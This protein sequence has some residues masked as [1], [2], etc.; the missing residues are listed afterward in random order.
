MKR[1]V[2]GKLFFTSII[3]IFLSS[4]I[5]AI[6]PTPGNCSIATRAE[7]IDAGINVAGMHILMGLSASTNAHGQSFPNSDYPSVLCCFFGMGNSTCLTTPSNK[8]IGLSDFTNAHAEAPDITP[9][10]QT[11]KVCYDDLSC[12][13]TTSSSCPVDHPKGILSLSS[14]TNAHL[15]NFSDFPTKICCGGTSIS[16]LSCT[17]K[18]ATWGQTSVKSGTGVYLNVV[19]S[20]TECSGLTLSFTIS[21]GSNPVTNPVSVSFNGNTARAIWYGER[22]AG[23]LG[24]GDA[25]YKFN[26]TL[27][28]S[29]PLRSMLSSNSLTVKPRTGDCAL[30]CG[31]YTD[32]QECITD[33]PCNVSTTEGISQG[34]ACDGIK[35]ICSCSWDSTASTCSFS[36]TQIKAGLTPPGYTLCKD[37]ISGANYNYPGTSCPGNSSASNFDGICDLNDGCSSTDCSDG[38]QASCAQGST[39]SGGKCSGAAPSKVNCSYGFTLC[40]SSSTPFCFPGNKCPSGNAPTGNSNGKCEVGEGCSLPLDCKDGSQDSCAD[41]TYCSGGKCGSVENPVTILTLGYCKITQTLIKDCNV[42]PV[43]YKSFTM[44]GTWIGDASTKTGQAYQDCMNWVN[45][46]PKNIPCPAQ[47]QLP[48]FDYYEIGIALIVIALIYLFLFRNKLKKRKK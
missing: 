4:G 22:Q 15:G 2:I 30:S 38:K 48:F 19:G 12:I 40:Q 27:V 3:L 33:S 42:E 9:N 36:Y 39:C 26:A 20:G 28:N 23:V 17:L 29:I 21:G 43:G 7:C 16:R 18:T 13:S 1:G 8:V 11:V 41:G 34:V 45:Q 10:Y 37:Q 46:P 24:L 14:S 44:S 35:T 5:F 6:V 31:D 32:S 25:S 47:V